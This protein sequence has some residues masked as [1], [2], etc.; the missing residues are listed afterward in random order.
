MIIINRSGSLKYKNLEFRCALG[1]AGIKK[2]KIEGDNITP[3]GIY[4]IVNIYCRKDRIKKVSSE[5]GYSSFF[6][7]LFCKINYFISRKIINTFLYFTLFI[8]HCF[9]LICQI[10]L[11]TSV[12]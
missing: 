1:K 11:Y 9:N 8:E 5:G 10:N 12:F 2:K 7:N 3:K 4:K 6:K